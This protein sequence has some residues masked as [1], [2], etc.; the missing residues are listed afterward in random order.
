M[1]ITMTAAAFHI[2]THVEYIKNAI[3]ID[4]F[5]LWTQADRVH[6]SILHY[7]LIHVSHWWR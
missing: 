6:S 4:L 2:D 1:T 5:E 7:Y 3:L